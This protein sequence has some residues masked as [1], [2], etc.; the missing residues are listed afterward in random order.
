MTYKHLTKFIKENIYES[1]FDLTA[2]AVKSKIIFA[3]GDGASNVCAMLSSIMYECEIPHSR[4]INI[5]YF[6]LRDRFLNN[7][8][9]VS[10]DKICKNAEKIKKMAN[11]IISGDDL[12]FCLSLSLLDGEYILI[13]MSEEYYKSLIGRIKF[14]PF[15]ILLCSLDDKKNEELIKITP[16][17]THVCALSQKENYDYIRPIDKNGRKTALV[18]KNKYLVKSTNLLFADFYHFSYLYR[19]PCIDSNNIFLAT[20]AI[21]SATL[22]FSAPRPY[23]YKGLS[24]AM[25]PC[26]LK[27]ISIS[28][29]ILL[30]I[31]D[32][33]FK[34][35]K[36]LS[37]DKITEVIP[38]QKPT[39]NTIFYG[40]K[41]YIDKIKKAM[42][43]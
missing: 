43:K 22:L 32:D 3:I 30:K 17:T 12:L 26:E 28:P 9:S 34:L 39:Q 7:N 24:N 18:S 10:L 1:N 2:L 23:I 40:N 16:N 4:Y 11:S 36:G 15:A 29:I 14:S 19:L 20:L 25:L 33:N 6:D 31:G 42:E 21:E 13:E 37:C 35:P 5:D 27:L 41:E 38:S 8:D